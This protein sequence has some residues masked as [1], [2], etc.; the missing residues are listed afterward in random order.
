MS[1][2]YL[3]FGLHVNAVV[4]HEKRRDAIVFSLFGRFRVDGRK[5]FEY[6]GRSLNLLLVLFAC[7]RRCTPS[8]KVPFLKRPL[9][10]LSKSQKMNQRQFSFW[11]FYWEACS[12]N[13]PFIARYF[14]LPYSTHYAPLQQKSCLRAFKN[15]SLHSGVWK[16]N[17]RD[18]QFGQNIVRDLRNVNVKRN[19]TATGLETGLRKFGQG[20]EM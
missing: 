8:L 20:C 12:Q 13:R 5:Q 6:A 2:F 16:G 11:K 9:C 19:F 1:S 10:L 18:P 17:S 7:R 15:A 4:G 3:A 14:H